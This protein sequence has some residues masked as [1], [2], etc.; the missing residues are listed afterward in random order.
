MAN[1]LKKK[2]NSDINIHLTA[3]R[4]M[5]HGIQMY[6]RFFD[7]LNSTDSVVFDRG[8]LGEFVYSPLYRDYSGEYVF[9]LEK[10]LTSDVRLVLLV[11][12]TNIVQ[13]DGLSHNFE[14]RHKEQQ[15][16]INGFNKSNIKDKRIIQVHKQNK[17][18]DSGLIIKDII[19]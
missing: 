12:D 8:H 5:E 18:I 4:D 7:I 19:K 2:L 13:D 15:M 6:S 9:D 16:F 11:G 17:F 10:E 3:P 1:L 14:N